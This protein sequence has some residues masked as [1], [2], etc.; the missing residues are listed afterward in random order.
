MEEIRAGCPKDRATEENRQKI[1]E[2]VGWINGQ[3]AR[4]A[5]AMK[6]LERIEALGNLKMVKESKEDGMEEIL[7]SMGEC[8][9]VYKDREN[10][11]EGH[12]FRRDFHGESVMEV[13]IEPVYGDDCE[14]FDMTVRVRG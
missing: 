4:A 10:G 8:F 13:M 12:P 9:R 1:N 14:G 11:L 3:E 5:K 2:M 7:E 6:K